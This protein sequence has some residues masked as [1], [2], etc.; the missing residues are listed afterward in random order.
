MAASGNMA[1]LPGDIVCCI[2]GRVAPECLPRMRAVCFAWSAAVPAEPLP[3]I[4]LQPD[5]HNDETAATNAAEQSS[6]GAFSVMS[7]PT[8]NKLPLSITCAGSGAPRCFGAGHGWL[9][10]VG[11]DLSVTLHNPVTGHAISLP[12]LTRHPM[13]GADGLGEDGLVLWH[14]WLDSWPNSG[15]HLVP[16]EEFRDKYVRKVVFSSWPRQDDYF[17]VV[18]GGYH[19]YTT[20]QL[21]FRRSSKMHLVSTI[22]VTGTK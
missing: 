20:T 2:A 1:D 16:A 21:T 12:P 8:D 17:A 7:L 4:L 9:A 10:L 13:V 19:S 6:G 11:A 5:D 14:T 22:S 15:D 3:W 18:L